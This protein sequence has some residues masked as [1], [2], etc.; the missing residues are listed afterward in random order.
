MNYYIGLYSP[1]KAKRDIDDIMQSMGF[2]DIAVRM[3]EKDKASRF[4]R[5]LFCVVKV[6]FVLQKGDLLL[7]QYPFTKY[8]SILCSIARLK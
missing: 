1:N 5:K 7:I 4:F 2:E 6:L 3:E 8:Y